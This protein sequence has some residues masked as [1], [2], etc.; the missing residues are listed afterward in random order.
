M[1]RVLCFEFKVVSI[2]YFMDKMQQYE[3]DTILDNL[4]F[5]NRTDWERTRLEIYSNLQM[6]TKKKLKTTDVITFPWEKEEQEEHITEISNEDVERLKMEA[7]KY[8]KLL[9]G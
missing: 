2:E 3:I 1:F 5:I 8:E 7:K 9:N 4:A 6:N